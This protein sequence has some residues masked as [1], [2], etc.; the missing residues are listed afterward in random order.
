[1][2]LN[3]AIV[4]LTRGYNQISKY[5]NLI[6]RNICIHKFLNQDCRYPL[7]IFHE[8]NIP[9]HHQKHVEEN[10][11]GQTIKW[12]DISDVWS[13][14]YEGMCRFQGLHLWEKCA[15]Y[16]Y[17]MRIDEDCFITSC[18][19]DPFTVIGDNVYLRSVYWSESHG[20]TNATLPHALQRL[21]GVPHEQYYNDK[22]VYT[23]VS[24]SSVK[25]W[26][27]PKMHKLL[28][29]LCMSHEQRANRWGDLPLLGALL[30]LY[31]KG[32]VGHMHGLTYSHQS[33]G[34]EVISD[35]TN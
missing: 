31:A 28:T 35:G 10:S 18:P 16:D 21:T 12:V 3:N 2:A 6:N 17:I 25:F 30:N 33:H 29:T 13:G 14:G 11:K 32:R 24:L 27:E 4:C 15:E 5:G 19:V 1:M 22:F 7:V 8:G 20:E 23:N 9:A 26:L 34:N